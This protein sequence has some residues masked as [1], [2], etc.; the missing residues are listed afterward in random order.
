MIDICN[1]R[2]SIVCPAVFFWMRSSSVDDC[3]SW[4][5][6][7]G[8]GCYN[9]LHTKVS[10][11]LSLTCNRGFATATMVQVYTAERKTQVISGLA[12][13]SMMEQLHAAMDESDT[14]LSFSVANTL[15]MFPGFVR[16]CHLRGATICFYLHWWGRLFVWM[17]LDVKLAYRYTGVR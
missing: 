11:W 7:V 17:D 15:A 6:H 9:M 10:L 14:K 13:F 8:H 1:F 4:P 2:S 3:M 12:T 16:P 5:A